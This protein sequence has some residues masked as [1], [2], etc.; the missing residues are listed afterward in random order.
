[1]STTSSS[2]S[3]STSAPTFSPAFAAILAARRAGFNGRVRD[4]LLRHPE[5]SQDDLR[6]FLADGVAALVDAVAALDG[7]DPARLDAVA[8]AA[9]D[10]A[11]EACA[12]RLV[13]ARARS[14]VLAA[15]WRTLFPSLA[16]LVA[17]S[18]ARVL[19]MLGNA[20][21]YLDGLPGARPAQWMDELAALAPRIATVG[22]LGAVG[23]LLA[24]RA[25][26]AHFRLGALAAGAGLPAPLA[27]AA[28]R[29]PE[30]A[31]WPALVHEIRDDPW[32]Q[33]RDGVARR[34]HAIG[35]FAGF[36]GVF[37]APP[38]VRVLDDG[39]VVRAG[40]RTFALL[41]DAYGAVLHPAPDDAFAAAREGGCAWEARGEVLAVGASTLALELPVDG[42]AVC[43]TAATIAL[44]SPFTHAIR[45]VRRR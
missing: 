31:S 1:M 27:L 5:L 12:R 17:A 14:P 45:L 25:G 28:L 10:L 7:V 8:D 19:G 32:W 39:F 9:V 42:L 34:E 20:V 2:T 22:Q 38:Q 4:A 30:G 43:A 18:P 36:G 41:A 13:G 40:E 37:E 6:D 44:T 15:A 11:L 35:A 16:P 29:A 3:S 24:W 23:Q 21:L 33:G 26:A